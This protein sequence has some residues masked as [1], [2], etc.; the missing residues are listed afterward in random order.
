MVVEVL[1]DEDVEGDVPVEVE[2]ELWLL[3]VITVQLGGC[4]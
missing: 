1:V 3:M 4:T 2:E